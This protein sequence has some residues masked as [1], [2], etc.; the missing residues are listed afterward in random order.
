M[1][2]GKILINGQ[3]IKKCEF[4]NSGAPES[5]IKQKDNPSIGF[6]VDI[7]VLALD[8]N[9]YEVSLLIGVDAKSNQVKLF[10]LS[11]EYAGMF[12][13]DNLSEEEKESILLIYC[14]N[15]LFPFVRRIIADITR[16]GGFPPLMMEPI[17]FVKL[18]QSKKNEIIKD[19]R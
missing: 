18:Y 11:L 13:L 6:T 4:D 9:N 3:Y 8:D 15:I 2:D 16:D 14:P 19:R 10:S 12:T 1:N 7:N 17:D 5:L